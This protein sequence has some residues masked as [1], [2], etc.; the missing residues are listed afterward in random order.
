MSIYQISNQPCYKIFYDRP[1]MLTWCLCKSYE[2]FC[3]SSTC[4]TSHTALLPVDVSDVLALSQCLMS[5]LGPSSWFSPW[6]VLSG[7]SSWFPCWSVPVAL[8]LALPYGPL[9]G[10]S[11]WLSC[12]PFLMVLLLAL[13]HGPLTGPSH[14]PL[15]DPFPLFPHQSSQSW[16]PVRSRL[17][18]PFCYRCTSVQQ[19]SLTY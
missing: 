2:S 1:L 12:W 4:L 5:L 10:P 14:G 17:S 7:P 16:W 11:L 6:P 19:H 13:P 3:P 8:L 15:A 18:S 9:A